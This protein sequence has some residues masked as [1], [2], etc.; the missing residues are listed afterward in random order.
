MHSEPSGLVERA[1]AKMDSLSKY[2][3]LD[4]TVRDVLARY[5]VGETVGV[6]GFAVVKRGKD[7]G[8]GE[9]VA[10]KVV[11]KWRYATEDNSERE[12]RIL[13]KVSHPHCIQLHAV[14]ITSRK[15]YIITELVS[16]GELLDRVTS[17]GVFSEPE[18]AHIIRQVLEGVAYLHRKGIVHRD[19]KLENLLLVDDSP[20]AHI[21]IADFGLSKVFSKD[22]TLSTVCGSPQYM[23]PELLMMGDQV[24]EYSPAVD[25]WSVGV[26]LF[27]LLA[28]YSPF[29]DQNDAALFA[30]I[31]TGKYDDDDPIWDNVSEGAKD[32]VARMLTVDAEARL[33]AQECL[34]HPWLVEQVRVFDELPDGQLPQ[35]PRSQAAVVSQRDGSLSQRLSR[36]RS[37]VDE[38][39][40]EA[41]ANEEIVEVQRENGMAVAAAAALDPASFL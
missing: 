27:I 28:G 18:A 1:S 20:K 16:G 7:R 6:G 9:V 4:V 21:K 5:E 2:I 39:R 25:V 26:I 12:I 29:D 11:D 37:I 23:A 8:T 22:T 10:I 14:Y 38:T 17:V 31:K 24:Q 32:L 19:L 36:A 35:L 34:Q 15:V 41:R 13:S 40:A 30:K 33:S 3:W